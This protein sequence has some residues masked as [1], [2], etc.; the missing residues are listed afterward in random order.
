MESEQTC[1]PPNRSWPRGVLSAAAHLTCNLEVYAG[2]WGLETVAS[3][4]WVRRLF[5]FVTG[6]SAVP[7]GL[8][9][10]AAGAPAAFLC[11]IFLALK[12]RTIL[13]TYSRV[14]MYGGTP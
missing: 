14:S 5:F 13:A 9:A 3:C 12:S 4:G 11:A 1:I 2:F 6:F 10:L 8:P 7:A